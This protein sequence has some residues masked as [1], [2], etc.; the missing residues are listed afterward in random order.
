MFIPMAVSTRPLQLYMS[1][2]QNRLSLITYVETIY[3]KALGVPPHVFP[4]DF[5]RFVTLSESP[6][7]ST[8]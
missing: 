2:R 4:N 6:F 8:S 5:H 7:R 1:A 3:T